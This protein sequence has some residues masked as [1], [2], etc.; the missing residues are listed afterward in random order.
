MS[1]SEINMGRIYQPDLRMEYKLPTDWLSNQ[2]YK[3][4]T[5]DPEEQTALILAGKCP[6]NKGWDYMGPRRGD[7]AYRCI[8]CKDYK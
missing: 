4:L 8:L 6:H 7:G 3:G 1:Y 2:I 5:P